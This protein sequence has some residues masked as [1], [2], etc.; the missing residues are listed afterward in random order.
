MPQ[1]AGSI[2]PRAAFVAIAASTQLPPALSMSTPT[3]AAS[4][5]LAQTIP[6]RATTA[7][8]SRLRFASRAASLGLL[9]MGRVA[10]ARASPD[11]AA[12]PARPMKLRRRIEVRRS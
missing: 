7:E 1:L 11:A 5:W 9:A 10:S 3:C 2:S 12:A 4:G 8:R 6:C